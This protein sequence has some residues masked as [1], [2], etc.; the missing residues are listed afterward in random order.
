[1][2]HIRYPTSDLFWALTQSSSV[3]SAAR[4]IG[5]SDGALRRRC[6]KEPALQAAFRQCNAR[7]KANTGRRCRLHELAQRSLPVTRSTP[8]ARPSHEVHR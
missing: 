7:G 4:L 2:S 1:M 6:E 8:S 5:M 3:V